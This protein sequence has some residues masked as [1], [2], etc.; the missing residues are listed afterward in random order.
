MKEERWKERRKWGGKV[1]R[2]E[3]K[4]GRK[5]RKIFVVLKKCQSDMCFQ[6]EVESE[7]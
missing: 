1:G 3:H 7:K 6:T 2:K 4:S 5:W